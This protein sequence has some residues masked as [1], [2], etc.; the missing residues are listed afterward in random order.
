MNFFS[1]KVKKIYRAET[2]KSLRNFFM[3]SAFREKRF[4][5]ARRFAT[6][7]NGLR[8]AHNASSSVCTG[9]PWAGGGGGPV[10]RA[11]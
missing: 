7:R 8:E 4:P 3:F 5:P 6:L 11:F 1:P 2:F 9:P 10:G